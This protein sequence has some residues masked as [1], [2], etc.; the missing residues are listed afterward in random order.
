MQGQALANISHRFISSKG[1]V[2]VGGIGIDW[3][4]IADCIS[5]YWI[6]TNMGQ[7]LAGIEP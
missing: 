7:E 6:A 3:S 1:F 5:G 4:S 2:L